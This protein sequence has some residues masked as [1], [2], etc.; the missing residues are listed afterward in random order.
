MQLAGK[1]SELFKAH[2]FI[3][4][5][6]LFMIMI[7]TGGCAS[8]MA[9]HHSDLKQRLDMQDYAAAAEQINKSKKKY[10]KKN[11]LMFYLDAGM[12]NQLAK[13][14]EISNKNF[15]LAKIKFD[16]YYQKS[17]SAGAASMVFNDMTI[18]YYGQDF[19]RVHITVFEAIN[20]IL[21]DK[22][23]EAAVEARQA[24]TMFKIFAANKN[25]KNYYKDDGFIRYFMGLVYEAGGYL[26]DAHISYYLA[27]NAYK[28]GLALITVPKDLI[29][30]AYT[31][32]LNLGMR[33][34][35]DEIKKDYPSANKSIIPEGYGECVFIVYNGYI[36]KKIDNV[37]EF[38][39]SDIWLYIDQVEVDDE[40][41]ARDFEK[42]RSINISVYAQDY[43]KV[44]FPKYKF[45]PNLIHS[46]YADTSQGKS[47]SYIAQ[48]LG[49]IAQK[50]LDNEIS[51]IYSKTLARAA[52]KYALG[53]SVVKMVD[54]STNYSGWGDLTQIAFNIYN[55]LSDTADKRGWNTL[56]EKILMS[57]IYLPAG[58]NEVTINFMS[59]DGQTI[60][61]REI[62]LE[63]K[64]GKK[65][66]VVL[67]SA[68]E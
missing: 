27:L 48:D 16:E 33:E 68:Y 26:N 15:E 66:F 56:P 63:I 36:P 43:V 23:D 37:L 61:T 25:N 59:L 49:Q 60:T 17:V 20:Y 51:K 44:A 9:K 62:E 54:D 58:M 5:L 41:E 4:L 24:D 50:T 28:K 29:N 2:P 40:K 21:L 34:R 64:E 38:I 65:N 39:L 42:A 55:S 46:F 35:A 19:E 47:Y 12:V 53:K 45:I 14:Y 32:A 57:R 22:I 31:S 18:P 1:R 10:G 7:M 3:I 30:D 8:N 11:I 67:R 6:S 52:V 13:E